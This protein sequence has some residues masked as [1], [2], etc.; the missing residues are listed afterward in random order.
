MSYRN[1][2]RVNVD[3]GTVVTDEGRE[4]DLKHTFNYYDTIRSLYYIIIIIIFDNQQHNYNYTT[5][6][7]S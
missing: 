1:G 5:V 4:L 6:F 3:G 2:G 7:L